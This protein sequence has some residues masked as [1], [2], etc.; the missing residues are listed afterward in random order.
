MNRFDRIGSTT[1]L[2]WKAISGF[3]FRRAENLRMRHG[4]N[5]TGARGD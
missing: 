5:L 3:H 1:D 2:G 4:A